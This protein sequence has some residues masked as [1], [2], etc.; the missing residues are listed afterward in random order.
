MTGHWSKIA[1]LLAMITGVV[2]FWRRQRSV[3]AGDSGI[4]PATTPSRV[5]G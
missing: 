2:V 3:D 1:A 5:G 4:E